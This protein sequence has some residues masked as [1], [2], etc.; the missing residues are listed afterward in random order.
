MRSKIKQNDGFSAMFLQDI[1]YKACYKTPFTYIFIK[2][3]FKVS[4]LAETFDHKGDLMSCAPTS[5]AKCN[6]KGKCTYIQVKDN[7]FAVLCVKYRNY[8]NWNMLVNTAMHDRDKSVAFTARYYVLSC[9]SAQFHSGCTQ[10]D[11]G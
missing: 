7:C 5:L 4:W 3:L 1:S 10:Y 6:C 8:R 11:V 9:L 2:R